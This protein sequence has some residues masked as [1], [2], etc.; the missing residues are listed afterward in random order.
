[1]AE[2]RVPYAPSPTVPGG[3]SHQQAVRELADCLLEDPASAAI[4]EA[5]SGHALILDRNRQLVAA[6][7]N[8]LEEL[9]LTSPESLQRLRPGP[10]DPFS[11]GH[12][13]FG[14]SRPYRVRCAPLRLR[15][16][17]LLL[18]LFEEVGAQKR[19]EA[20]DQVFLHD[21]LNLAGGL[22]GVAGRL[23]D[24]ALEPEA[25]AGQVRELAHQLMESIRSQRR[26]LS[27]EA[28]GPRAAP[29]PTRPAE[30]LERL[31]RVFRVHEAA[32]GRRL[33]VLPG[34]GDPF[35]CDPVLL[36]R[37]LVNLVRNAL[38]A[39]PDGGTVKVWHERRGDRL[40]FVVENPG[41][42]PPEVSG[43]IFERCFS[44]KAGQ[45]GDGPRGLGAYGAKLLGEQFLG[46]EVGFAS[47]G[48]QHTRFFIWMPPERAAGAAGGCQAPVLDCAQ[49]CGRLE[50]APAA[51]ADTLLVVDDSMAGCHLL[52][53]LLCPC[54]RVL[55][56]G[57]G[58]AGFAL[59]LSQQPDLI[60]L[61]VK[62]P[63]MDGFAVCRRL[64]EDSRTREIPVLFLTAL[65]DE[66]DE[67]QALEA[68]GIDFLQK[69]VPPAVLA[70]RVRNQ[71]ELKH[72]QDRLRHLS[73][74]DALTGIG[75]RRRFD[76]YL[77]MEW[78]R[79]SR[80][81]QPL[82]LVMGDVDYF[83]AFNDGYG[84]GAGDDCL[85]AVA[86]VFDLALRRPADLAA[87]YGGEE[88]V[89]L[90]PE[91][92]QEGARIVAD[93]IMAQL[94]DLALPHRLNPVAPRVT[95]SIGVAT[96]S[97]PALAR[98]WKTL[99]EEADRWLYAA[100]GRGRNRIEG[101]GIC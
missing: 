19:R 95:V 24:P 11:G 69:P 6:H 41:L 64:K 83:K 57:T 90:L 16:E 23:G 14:R 26:L 76:Q 62:M 34:P 2:W 48:G 5:L 75:N 55:M 82:S 43:R 31:L 20:L 13:G 25:A 7:G 63:D 61:D 56:A 96:A 60:L 80:N 46:G 22:D 74:L 39:A 35:I 47:H 42:I 68:G 30:V 89:C 37:V 87:R 54:Y 3:G 71:L 50:P 98:S 81:G 9:G 94:E 27:A 73:L 79:C 72:Q 58:E 53:D 100:K 86:R 28:G 49:P 15:G 59:A 36:T 67:M 84:H 1:M 99:V 44:T 101:V 38:E 66:A 33:E 10:F 17:T 21:L 8:V 97:R 45:G 32:A 52:G 91:T 40:G 78:Q 18:F 93:Q 29:V 12:D 88:F 65:G 70:A 77:E 4:L 51:G 92:D 85:Q